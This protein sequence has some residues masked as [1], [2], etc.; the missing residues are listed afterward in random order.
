VNPSPLRLACLGLVLLAG[1]CSASVPVFGSSSS[2]SIPDEEYS[3]Y[4]LVI[5]TKFLTS[6]TELVLIDRMTVTNL[7]SKEIPATIAFFEEQRFFEGALPVD[8]ILDF[9]AKVRRPWRLEPKF[10]PGVHYR[11]VSGE[12]I[13]EP[14]VSLAPLPAAH[15]GRTVIAY[16]PVRI[17]VLRFSRVGFNRAENLALVYVGDHRPDGSGA[18]FLMFLRRAGTHWRIVDTEVLW[19]AQ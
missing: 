13:E 14:E 11:F 8:G 17:G 6:R 4:D 16:D 10:N 1:F 3:I 7:G 18:G 5:Q 9:V 2:D 15:G 19:V 12:T